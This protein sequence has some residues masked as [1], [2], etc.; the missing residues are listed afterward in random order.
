[1]KIDDV[2]LVA[3]MVGDLA[4]LWDYWSR[5]PAG[6]REELE[7]RHDLV[8]Q[9]MRQQE[10]MGESVLASSAQLRTPQKV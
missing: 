7:R 9:L 4:A 10:K 6:T 8:M 3:R 2:T 5:E 1:M